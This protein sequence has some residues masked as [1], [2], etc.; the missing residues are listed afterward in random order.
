[1]ERPAQLL[2]ALGS[3]RLCVWSQATGGTRGPGQ[4]SQSDHG[5]RGSE[6]AGHQSGIL[7]DYRTL[8]MKGLLT[9]AWFLACSVSAVPG[10]LLQLKVMIEKV[11][12]KP[13]LTSY[14]FY[15]C[16]CGWGGQGTPK[17]CTDW[18]CWMHD[19]CYARLEK[20]GCNALTQVYR[21]RIACGLVTCGYAPPV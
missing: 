1:M 15:G 20:K 5:T 2:G 14:G 10:S 21:Y 4:S 9:L 7:A 16:Y 19:H 18:C 8:E 12:R 3:W 13:A 17:D 6:T 11:T